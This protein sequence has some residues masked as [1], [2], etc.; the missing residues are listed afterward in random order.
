MTGTGTG[1]CAARGYAIAL[2]SAA[3][4]S[5]TAIF[6]RHLTETYGLPPLVL[7]FWRDLFV[8]LTL[9]PLLALLRPGLLAPGRL[10]LPYLAAYGAI[11]AAFNALWTASVALNGA[12]VSTVLV[13]CSAG[14]TAVL[15]WRLL[16][17]RLGATKAL[18]VALCLGG[19]ALVSGASDPASWGANLVGIVAGALSGLG[20]AVYTLM[21][22][23]ASLRGL[24]SWTTLLYTFGFAALFLLA[25]NLL[26]AGPLCGGASHPS[27][28]FWLGDAAAG[29]GVLFLLAAGP[30]AAGYGL[31]VLSLAHL[32]SSTVNL[33]V[34]LEVVFTAVLAYVLL[35]ERLTA[36][37][38]AGSLL[39]L[40]A[41]VLLRVREGGTPE[42]DRTLHTRKLE[43]E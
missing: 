23:S 20:Y 41:V 8:V 22:R 31:Y 40:S 10:H 4:L 1:A 36:L 12:A 9:V 28:L 32:P 37:Q 29:W 38:L 30:T 35:G 5:T 2:V 21:G 27:D 33:V 17:E 39:I 16:G 42:N 19:C 43:R 26:P 6:I 13:Y 25:L 15:G 14:F 34:T 11:L 24:N 7:A 18:A 3:V